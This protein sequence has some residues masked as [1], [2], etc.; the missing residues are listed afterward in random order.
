MLIHLISRWVGRSRQRRIARALGRRRSTLRILREGLIADSAMDVFYRDFRRV[1][2]FYKETSLLGPWR[3]K[4]MMSRQ[5][6]TVR[7]SLIVRSGQSW[8]GTLI[9]DQHGRNP[10]AVVPDDQEPGPAVDR[11]LDALL[12]IDT[13][14]THTRRRAA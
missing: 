14:D 12:E 2:H 5:S 8:I 3:L 6:Q 11:L 13:R 4:V 9:T 7:L 1:P 10:L